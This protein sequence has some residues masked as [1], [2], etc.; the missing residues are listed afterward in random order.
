MSIP[1]YSVNPEDGKVPGLKTFMVVFR[2]KVSRDV[3]IFGPWLARKAD[4]GQPGRGEKLVVFVGILRY[5]SYV[6]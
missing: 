3:D 6:R 2:W 4:I 1:L 5:N